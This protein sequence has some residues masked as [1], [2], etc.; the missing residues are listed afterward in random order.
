MVVEA[1]RMVGGRRGNRPRH[2]IWNLLGLIY[3]SG[4]GTL[5]GTSAEFSGDRRV[6][7]DLSGLPCDL[8]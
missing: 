3:T 8:L 2:P 6:C 5:C 1:S 7:D 4:V